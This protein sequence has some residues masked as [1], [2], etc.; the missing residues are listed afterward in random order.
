MKRCAFLLIL[1]AWSATAETSPNAEAKLREAADV[2]AAAERAG[3]RVAALTQAVR[4]YEAGLATTRAELRRLTLRERELE[5]ALASEDADLANLLAL[6][7]NATLQAKTQSLLHPGSAADTLRAG[8][9]ARSMVPTL[10]ERAAVLE[11]QLIELDE[12][13]S[14]IDGVTATL[15]DG[16]AG[17]QTARVALGDALTGRNDLPE[18]LGTNEAAMQALINSAD[19]LS[20]LADSLL[21]DGENSSSTGQAAWRPPVAGRLLVGFGENVDRSGWSVATA[22]RALVTAPAAL[23]VRFSGEFPDAGEVVILEADGARLLLLAGLSTRFVEIGQVLAPGDP[24][25]FAGRGQLAAQDNLNVAEGRSS[26]NLN[27]T[28]YIELRQGGAPVD[29]AT[30]LTLEQEQG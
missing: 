3:D 21:S 17:V 30:V 11:A 14:L 8:T 23:S 13:R 2:L 20:G 22:P 7:Q 1:L 4:A 19:S 26:L 16:L 29:P 24:I 5:A 28:L 10:F 18:R 27:E 15:E 6:M 9:L 12:T 25:G